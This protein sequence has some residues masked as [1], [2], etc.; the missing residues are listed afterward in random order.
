MAETKAFITGYT[1]IEMQSRE[2]AIEWTTRFPNPAVHG[3]DGE[4]EVP[5]LYELKD[6][7]PNEAIDF[8]RDMGTS[9]KK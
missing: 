4:I 6:F 7:G 8:L 1:L 5:P 9:P 3:Q 2:Q